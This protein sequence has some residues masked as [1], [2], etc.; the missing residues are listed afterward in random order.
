MRRSRHAISWKDAPRS[1][2]NHLAAGSLPS[3]LQPLIS[4]HVSNQ[5]LIVEAALTRNKNLAFQAVYNDPVTDLTVDEA[6]DMFSE[7]LHA[8]REYLPGWNV[9]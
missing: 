4:G 2:C 8:T 7:M 6:W 9:D 5:E 1:A 3:G